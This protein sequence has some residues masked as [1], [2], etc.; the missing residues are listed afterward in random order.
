MHIFGTDLAHTLAVVNICENLSIKTVTSIQGLVS[1]MEKHMY[2]SLPT[3]TILY[4]KIF[5]N[6]IR[7][8][9]VSGL[10]KL[11]KSNN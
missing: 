5:R 11:F 10:K 7:K 2:S 6:I 9:N 4:G 3:Y 8:D 1:I